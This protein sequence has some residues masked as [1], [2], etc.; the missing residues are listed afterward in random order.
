VAAEEGVA[1]IAI[2]TLP[3][4]RERRSVAEPACRLS[5][6]TRL[7]NEQILR[8]RGGR[9]LTLDIAGIETSPRPTPT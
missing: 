3:T 7:L 4:L 1:L 8:L 2:G 6:A 9:P 5:S